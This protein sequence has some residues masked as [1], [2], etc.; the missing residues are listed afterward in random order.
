MVDHNG[1]IQMKFI[2]PV[3]RNAL[4]TQILPKVKAL[5]AAVPPQTAAP[6]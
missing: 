5:Q 6:K 2:G 4:D 3:D 1:K